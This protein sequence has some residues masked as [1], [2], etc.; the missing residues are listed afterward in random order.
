MSDNKVISAKI[1]IAVIILGGILL[2]IA[3]ICGG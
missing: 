2:A 1:V 3:K